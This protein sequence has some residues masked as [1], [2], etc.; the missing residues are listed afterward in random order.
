ML[1]GAKRE[2]PE[3]GRR[4]PCPHHERGAHH[5]TAR[6]HDLTCESRV[7][8]KSFQISLYYFRSMASKQDNF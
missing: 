6:E 2:G 7:M 3:R 5:D 4:H 1:H 8:R